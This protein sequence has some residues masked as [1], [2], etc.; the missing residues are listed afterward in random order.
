VHYFDDGQTVDHARLGR[1][2][3][4]VNRN[5]L[6]SKDDILFINERQINILETKNFSRVAFVE[7][8]AMTVGRIA[9]VHPLDRPFQG[10]HEK[11]VFKF[12]GSA[13]VVFGEPGAWTP[14]QDLLENTN[15]GLETLLRLGETVASNRTATGQ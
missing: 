3:W 5:A 7:I 4:T 6:Q 10:G 11:A 8:G 2:L 9:Q 1:R 14:A 13:I 12:G 15:K